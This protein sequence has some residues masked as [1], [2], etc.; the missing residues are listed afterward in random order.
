MLM[1]NVV[2]CMLVG[3]GQQ[4][5]TLL[6]TPVRNI[7]LACL[8]KTVPF[9]SKQNSNRLQWQGSDATFDTIHENVFAMAIIYYVFTHV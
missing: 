9:C 2:C 8:I 6:R 7:D 4:I 5:C 3:T 1:A